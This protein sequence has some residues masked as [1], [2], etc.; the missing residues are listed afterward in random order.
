MLDSRKE[1]IKNEKIIMIQANVRGNQA[2]KKMNEDRDSQVSS[3]KDSTNVS[4]PDKLEKNLSANKG[5]FTRFTPRLFR[6]VQEHGVFVEIK[7][8]T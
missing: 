8:F 5:K 3:K 1:E 6:F 2:R 7:N 4:S